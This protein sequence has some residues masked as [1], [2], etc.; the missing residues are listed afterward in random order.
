MICPNISNKKVLQ[1][2]NEIVEALGGKP[3][4][5]EEFKNAELRNQRTGDD[6]SAMEATYKIWHY[7]GDAMDYAPNGAQSKLFQDL[8]KLTRGDRA[9][10][11][12]LKAEIY[13]QKF[14]QNFSKI[15]KVGETADINGE[16]TLENVVEIKKKNI[17]IP[18]VFMS[19]NIED[20]LDADSLDILSNEQSIDSSTIVESIIQN[21]FVSKTNIALANML[22]KHNI[23]VI[24]DYNM[25]NDKI[26]DTITDKDGNS[27]IT[28]NPNVMRNVTMQYASKAIL[29]E[30][31][32][33]VTVDAID[34]PKT[35]QDIKFSE[36]TKKVFR[37]FGRI[38]QKNPMLLS[39]VESGL[40]AFSNE[41]EF[42]AV[43][44]TDEIVR[45]LVY[46][47]ARESDSKYSTRLKNFIN[48][49]V[50]L[51]SQKHLFV[52]NEQMLSNYEQ[53][54]RDYLQNKQDI[55][56]DENSDISE[57][58]NKYKTVSRELS[59]NES[60][61][62]F[63]NRFDK[64]KNALRENALKLGPISVEKIQK[65][66]GYEYQDVIN[67]LNTRLKALRAASKKDVVDKDRLIMDTAQQIEMFSNR[68][69]SKYNA[70]TELVRVVTPQ[71]LADTDELREKYNQGV[72]IA[73]EEYM[74]QAHA[75]IGMFKNLAATLMKI[76]EDNE[77]VVHMI[78]DYNKDKSEADYITVDDI[79]TLKNTVKNLSS[80][81]VEGE[82]VIQ[83]VLQKISINT[84]VKVRNEVGAS[85]IDPYLVRIASGEPILDDDVSWFEQ[86]LGAADSSSSPVI[87]ALAY[88]L[89]RAK[90]KAE[91]E[92]LHAMHD[93]LKAAE[94][95]DLSKVYE[96]TKEGLS[97]YVIRRLN[98]GQFYN[99]YDKEMTRINRHI[100]KKYGIQIDD[101]NRIA[102]PIEEARVEWHMMR[103]DWLDKHALRRYNKRYYD[104]WSKVPEIAR[105][106]MNSYNSEISAI[107]SNPN[108]QVDGVVKYELISDE[109]WDRFQHLTILKKL[110]RSDHDIFGNKKEEG[111]EA[112][113]IY[114]ALQQLDKDLY[115][116]DEKGNIKRPEIEKDV[117]GWLAERNRQIEL[118]GG[119]DKFKAYQNGEKNHGFDEERFEK[120][121]S[122]NTIKTL[123]RDK[124]GN[125][126]VFK[127]IDEEMRG[128]NVNTAYGPEY[129]RL[130]KE[131]RDILR[132][133][134]DQASEV[135]ADEL[136][137]A[138]KNYLLE[139]FHK[140]NEIRRNVGKS[141]KQIQIIQS[142]YKEVFDQYLRREDTE[143]FKKIKQRIVDDLLDNYGNYDDF[144]FNLMLSDYGYDIM[145]YETGDILDVQPYRWL[146]KLVAIDEQYMDI[147]PGNAWIRRDSENKFINQDFELASHQ[148]GNEN[149]SM[150]PKNMY[151]NK[152]YDKIMSDPKYRKLHQETLNIIQKANDKQTNR[153]FT[154][155]YMLPQIPATLMNRMK[156]TPKGRYRIGIFF[157]WLKEKLGIRKDSSDDQVLGTTYAADASQNEVDQI[158]DK[159]QNSLR[160]KYP[161]GRS[162]NII[163]QFYTRRMKD[164]SL[165]STDL[166]SILHQ[167]YLM[168]ASY[169]QKSK[170]RGECDAL[171][172][173]L[174]E[175]AFKETSDNTII[176]G[177][178]TD[179]SKTY[180]A[181]RKF[182]EMNLYNIRRNKAT[183]K[184][185]GLSIEY[186]KAL[187]LW[188][189]YATARNLG[190]NPK[191]AIVGTATSTY[192]H[193]INQLVG[194]VPGVHDKYDIKIGIAALGEM[195]LRVTARSGFGLTS[196][197]NPRSNDKMMLLM[198]ECD[199]TNQL[200]RKFM[201]SDRNRGFGAI[202][203]NYVYGFLT[204][205][206]FF[207]K[208]Q[209]M[210]SE[211]M[212]YRF[213]DGEF[214]TKSDLYYNRK[215]LGEKAFKEKLAKFKKAK[216][217]YSVLRAKDGTI[218]CDNQYKQAWDNVR[219]VVKSRAQKTAEN[220]DGMATELQRNALTANIIGALAQMHRQ[221]MSL[222]IQESYG[223]QVYDYD[224]QRYKNAQLRTLWNLTTDLMC[225]NIFA[226]MIAGGFT[227]FALGGFLGSAVGVAAAIPTRFAYKIRHSKSQQKEMSFKKVINKYL[228]DMESR[229]SSH[230]S[231]AN[232][233]SIVKTIIEVLLFNMCLQPAITAICKA[234]DDD[235]RWQIQLLLYCLRA[236]SW[237]AYTKYRTAELF[238]NIKSATGAASV[239]D[240]LIDVFSNTS[241]LVLRS[242][243][244][245]RNNALEPITSTF[246]SDF[247]IL[248]DDIRSGAYEGH[249][250]LVRSLV[251]MTPWHNAYEQYA[252]PK[253]KR[254]YN[255]LQIQKLPESER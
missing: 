236:F 5:I 253:T 3:L 115:G 75:N 118:C 223:K 66:S 185:L 36:N 175:K 65:K 235:D 131:A 109:D 25:S 207:I 194:S 18:A 186:T 52:T 106:A 101:D 46:Q 78:N 233:A 176:G 231:Y 126:L 232:R 48:S 250:R 121:E 83:K 171:L 16:P 90:E 191:V 167:Y 107:L 245:P 248:G 135:I 199:L 54:F 132:P 124:N 23:P 87:R 180:K 164:P 226:G 45:S 64:Y 162:F 28:I 93:V 14:L 241:D 137:E 240:G 230:C 198:E 221:Y 247:S 89:G 63:F 193:L 2:F 146:Q 203:K 255:E 204:L 172:D 119:R 116:V 127:K 120:W 70:I 130:E 153:A 169:E 154:D 227:G 212:A 7:N 217:L 142:R 12:R 179:D 122:R 33:A 96:K 102:P 170:I 62:D 158:F 42:A 13:S 108:Y 29:H 50:G 8:L 104:A 129:E 141:N 98:Y 210:I 225:G 254:K 31:V 222:M 19:G 155:K 92:S 150:I 37:T 138:T 205:G 117:D 156:H 243:T 208:S 94:G 184:K 187:D 112:Y 196:I 34:N 206:D 183:I 85:D 26:A 68:F 224:T 213:V 228:N 161:D 1:D 173:M 143:Y 58:L 147:Q 163:P 59:S 27:V 220:A 20:M 134:K 74:Y 188:K 182:L 177:K 190:A 148:E 166:L 181:A 189:E 216:S 139:I 197:S 22:S 86:Y 244:D 67:M 10:A 157:D 6:Y 215:E 77:N 219:Y 111:S 234:W 159:H 100:S 88:K 237:E 209:I 133:F 80:I 43:F 47:I 9:E 246:D 41:R 151:L 32:H 76:L 200:Q 21:G 114:E 211:F 249:S 40:Y 149:V 53:Q 55:Q 239:T 238:N 39:D 178:Q 15:K 229:D 174:Q 110:L 60:V 73:G 72:D 201:Y 214:V 51:F 35:S 38:V 30:I 144:L 123:K 103:N 91:H 81:C 165:I 168:S 251:K 125:V 61:I 152:D 99:D 57:L 44:I 97:G 136:S 113:K 202:S 69:T 195:L 24:V 49:I 17:D 140:M 160:G 82:A 145:D 56:P 218:Q 4:S 192:V 84:L 79:A 11:I 71:I 128:I 242:V 105:Q 95:L 252:D